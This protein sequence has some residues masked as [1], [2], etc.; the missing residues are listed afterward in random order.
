[1][2]KP[3][4]LKIRYDPA[5]GKVKGLLARYRLNT[6]CQSARCPNRQECWASGTA[7]FMVLGDEC[8]RNCRFCAIK[9]N[10]KPKA[11]DQTEPERLAKAVS[12]LGLRYVVL[13]SVDR[14]DLPDFGAGHFAEC[15]RAIKKTN[16]KIL[17]EALVPDFNCDKT[18]IQKITNSG[19]DVLGHNIETVERLTPKVR[20]ARAGYRKSLDVLRLFR[21][22]DTGHRTPAT[23]SSLMLGL[24]ETREEVTK[25]MEDLREAKVD[26]LTMGQYLQP[27]KKQL[28]VERYVH[29]DEF[30]EYE[31]IGRDIG[32]RSVISGPF[33]RSSYHAEKA[34]LGRF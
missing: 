6:V 29:P 28:P 34:L 20:D 32:F 27:S 22:L 31:R 3:P 8:T 12:E 23:K 24:G 26:I 10:P 7:T 18:A 25:A 17:V 11:P 4:W 33:V 16:P 15:I 9:T 14:D 5:S 2:D 13:T 21:T 30:R 1:M 19:V